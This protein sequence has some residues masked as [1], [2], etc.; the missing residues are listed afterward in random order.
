MKKFKLF[1]L[2]FLFCL[3]G[4]LDV[5]GQNGTIRGNATDGTT[6]EV[7][8]FANVLVVG[9]SSGTQT[10]LDG[11]YELSL[12]PGVYALEISYIGFAS[13]TITDINVVEGEVTLV[14]FVM[15]DE[16]QEL[17]EVVV[18]S[19]RIDRTEN[20]LLAL[21]KKSYTIQDGISSQEM[22]RYGG[23]SAAESVKR[24]SGAALV[25]GKYINVRGL[26][27][28]YANAQLNGLQLPS[29]DPYRNSTPLDLIPSNLL[30]NVIVSKAFSPDQPGNFTGGSVNLKTK[31]FP[32]NFTLSFSSSFAYNTVSSLNDEFLTYQGGSTD[33]LGFDD[34]TRAIPDVLTN[35][36][37]R[38]Q[39]VPSAR[40]IARRDDELATLVDEAS[41]SLNPQKAPSTFRTPVDHSVSFS[42]GNQFKIGG[43]PLG[44]LFGVNYKRNYRGYQNGT[45]QNWELP[46]AGADALNNN[47]QLATDTGTESPQIGGLLNLAYK[48]GGS[49]KISLNVFYNH[50]ANK[51]ATFRQG[52]YSG[53]IS[54]NF[55]FQTRSLTFVER[56]LRNIQLNGEHVLSDLGNLKIEWAG[57][58][59]ELSQDEP[60]LRFF[61]NTVDSD[62]DEDEDPNFFITPS[63]FDLPFHYWRHLTDQQVGARVDFTLPFAKA[64][65]SANKIKFGA[66]YNRKE[67]TFEEDRFQFQTATNNFEPFN[68]DAT[69][70]FAPS[71][72]GILGQDNRDR[73][74]VGLFVTDEEVVANNYFGE[75]EVFAAYGMV[76][77]DLNRFRIVTG[78]RVETTDFTVTSADEQKDQGRIDEVDFLPSLNLIY[79]VNDKMNI[80]TSFNQ[81]LARPNMREVAP[82]SAFDFIGGP[83]F[84]G[85][86][87]LNRTLAQNF[88]LRWEFF[89]NTG[90]VFAISG[91]YK[92][93]TDPI[94]IRFIPESQNPEVKPENV[95]NARVFGVEFEFRKNLGFITNA[96]REFKFSTNLSIIHSEVAIP[97][98]ELAIIQPLNP[99]FGDTRTFQGQSPFLLNTALTYSNLDNGIDAQLSFNLFGQRLS[100]VS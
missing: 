93:F 79:R 51:T 88:D 81:T 69:A 74:I 4:L 83:I 92:N 56:E 78:L 33:W 53:I 75:E 42:I 46:G 1:S 84:T 71:N 41:R 12:S 16:S 95:D 61:A 5:A 86:T 50:D 66:A 29:T 21:Q 47:F 43:N 96:L 72:V 10:D 57:N 55:D 97:E 14:D 87:E 9:T 73:N 58:L 52:P 91:Y 17:A 77:Y 40:I 18:S 89:P 90:E 20:A 34:G 80:R 19:K 85:N 39:L 65:S 70:F 60:D 59:V 99:E 15:E 49:N 2:T 82:F 3:I 23:S 94:I 54:G 26:G 28:R 68:G 76:S 44:V 62:P 11:N 63:E 30:E 35:E 100:E 13:Q 37:N 32:E 64:K 67:R 8:L 98:D 27:D 7:L 24:V 22:S 31:S 38:A 25:G 36:E 6:G 45:F 48:F